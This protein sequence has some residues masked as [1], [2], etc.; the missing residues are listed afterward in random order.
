MSS[1]VASG[2]T[3]GSPLRRANTARCKPRLVPVC[4]RNIYPLPIAQGMFKLCLNIIGSLIMTSTVLD[5]K[6]WGNNLGVRLPAAIAHAAHLHA[7]Q[8]VQITVE[9]ERVIITPVRDEPLTLQ[10]RLA[11]FDP[12]RHGGE[13]MAAETMLGAEK[14]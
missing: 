11:R 3:P 12:S 5:I 8:R 6:R 7:D 9:G 1:R 13:T 14:W 10:Q 4:A 2:H